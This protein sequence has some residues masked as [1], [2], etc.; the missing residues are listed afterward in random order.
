MAASMILNLLTLSSIFSGQKVPSRHR[1]KVKQRM[2]QTHVSVHKS[3]KSI[4]IKLLA[5]ES[6]LFFTMNN[7][8][9]LEHDLPIVTGH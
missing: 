6:G 9:V 2:P 8:A 4:L 3:S 1:V 5:Q 7:P